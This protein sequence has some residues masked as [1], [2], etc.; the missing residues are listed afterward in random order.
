MKVFISHAFGGADERLG[1]ILKGYLEAAGTGGYMAERTPQYNL[2][3]ADKIMREIEGSD[4]LVAIITK[5]GRESASVHEEIGYAL[6]RGVE[7]A[8]M[9]RNDVEEAGVFVHGRESMIFTPDEFEKRSQEMAEFIRSTPPQRAP[10]PW[11]QG[12]DVKQFLDDRR[13]LSAESHEFALNTHYGRIHS[14]IFSGVEKPVVLF[15]ACPHDLG[16]CCNTMSTGFEE[17]AKGIGHF[18]VGGH[19]IPIRGL[20]P[21]LGIESL[22][23]IEGHPDA[24]PDHIIRSY[25][26]F[27]N[28][29][30]FECGASHPPVVRNHRA[31][32]SLHLCL[33]IGNF[34]GFL[35][36]TRLFY[37]KIGM[38]GPFTVLLSVRNSYKLALGNYGNEVASPEWSYAKGQSLSIPEP[39][40]G[41]RHIR[42]LHAFDSVRELTDQAIAGA[43]REMARKICS[44]Y[45]QDAPKCYSSDGEFAW[46]LWERV[47]R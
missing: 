10:R 6:G 21:E 31:K 23:V 47:S 40:T 36:H 16:K 15:T 34:W 30:F 4:W 1:G 9:L 3:I 19:R 44:V 35:L 28:N 20:D 39:H 43:A 41:Q 37:Q 8:L 22:T 2:P 29:G 18:D 14:D 7:V 11:Q 24:P 12:Q 27:Q 46:K 26:E 38:D 17:W 45:G 42:L 25:R 5:R 13:L 32:P 33:L